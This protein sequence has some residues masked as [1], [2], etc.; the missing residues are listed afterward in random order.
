MLKFETYKHFDASEVFSLCRS[1][2]EGCFNETYCPP[3]DG[4]IFLHIPKKE[5]F[6]S[7]NE[8]EVEVF[9]VLLKYGGVKCD[10]TICLDFSY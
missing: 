7:Y 5:E 4:S 2:T 6:F 10:E 8:E 3:Q 9:E 1:E